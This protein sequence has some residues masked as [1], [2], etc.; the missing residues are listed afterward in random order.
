M[1]MRDVATIAFRVLALW[2]MISGLTALTDLLFNWKTVAA[3]VMGTFSGASNPPTQTE[4]LW[5]SATAFVG[6]SVIGMVAWW[7]SPLVAR[8]TS[9]SADVI[10]A[11]GR[12]DLYAAASFLVGLYLIALSAPGLAF[13]GYAATRPG[14]PAYPEAHPQVPFLMAQLVLGVALLRSRWLVRWAIGGVGSEAGESASEGTVQQR[15]A[16]DEAGER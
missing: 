9:P 5:M 8:A 11:L 4:L 10:T 12:E 1:K 7:V 14:F 3:Q 6:R 2:I 15:D 13:E 16:A